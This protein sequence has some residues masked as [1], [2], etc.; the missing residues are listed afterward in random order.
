MKPEVRNGWTLLFHPAFHARF[1][2]LIEEVSALK[3]A[4]P[5]A[6]RDHPKAKLLERIRRLVFDEI[7]MDPEASEFRQGNTLGETNRR[8]RRAKF[9]RRFRLF[10][11]FDSGSKVIIIAWVND[12]NTL[13]KAGAKT[14]PYAVFARQLAGGDPPTDWLEL[15]ARAKPPTSIPQPIS[16]TT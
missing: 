7:P 16:T 1:D 5:K 12:E 9:L 10:F 4:E 15:L 8:W 3:T 13:R 2:L 14:D 6:W 11:R